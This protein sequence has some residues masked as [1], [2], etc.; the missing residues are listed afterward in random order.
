MGLT[1]FN[2]MGFGSK[3]REGNQTSSK[4]TIINV[5]MATVFSTLI[6]MALA[7]LALIYRIDFS[8]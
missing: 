4:E 1:I 2:Y 8:G 3:K 5:S 7:F 6:Y